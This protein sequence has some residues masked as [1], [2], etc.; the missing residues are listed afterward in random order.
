VTRLPYPY[1]D[2]QTHYDECWRMQRHHNCAVLEVER[3]EAEVM[4]LSRANI[5]L[6]AEAAEDHDRQERLRAQLEAVH[7]YADGLHFAGRLKDESLVRTALGLGRADGE[8]AEEAKEEAGASPAGPALD[9]E[10][11]AKFASGIGGR[12]SGAL[13][14]AGLVRIEVTEAGRRALEGK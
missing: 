6:L 7:R 2:G 12:R 9:L 14:R 3:L 13:M 11:L 10:L 4:R 8:R 5:A 1:L